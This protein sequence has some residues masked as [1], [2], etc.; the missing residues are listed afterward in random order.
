MATE[1]NLDTTDAMAELAA[2][3]AI[4]SEVVLVQH[5]ATSDLFNCSLVARGYDAS[6]NL[7]KVVV[8]CPTPCKIGQAFNTTV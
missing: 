8:V 5:D 7:I 4:R 2:A 1:T 6:N 3:G